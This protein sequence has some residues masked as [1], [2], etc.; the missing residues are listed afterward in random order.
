MSTAAALEQTG[1]TFALDS[2]LDFYKSL[3]FNT[4]GSLREA[5]RS[6]RRQNPVPV[7]SP[8]VPLLRE[9]V[10][11]LEVG[12]GT[13]WMSNSMSYH[14][15]CDVTGID[16]NPIAIDQCDAVADTLELDTQ[17]RVQ[18]LFTY[19]PQRPF[20]VVVSLGVLHHTGNCIEAIKRVCNHYVRPGG[21]VLIGL[22]HKPGREPF[23]QHFQDMQSA[24]ATEQELFE[25][26]KLIHGEVS[27]DETHAKSW[28]RDQVL[29]PHESQHTLAEV[30]P[31]VE[32]CNFEILSTSLN[33]WAP[34]ESLN[35]IY[36]S[37]EECRNRSYQNLEASKYYPGFFVFLA[38]KKVK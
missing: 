23:L 19:Q 5:A 8:L 27:E 2:V 18:D 34:F 26:Y 1:P 14:Y 29:H 31:I 20:D 16:F 25:R 17:F 28:F 24:G 36:E 38:Q 35:G 30:A 21:H 33:Q 11:V 10:R 22:Y 15:N 9:G 6:I 4:R 3:P 37:E 7:Y 13:G 32:A 12:C